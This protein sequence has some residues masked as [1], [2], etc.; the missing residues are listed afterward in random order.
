MMNTN[1]FKIVTRFLTATI[2]L[3][4][5]IILYACDDRNGINTQESKESSMSLQMR[6]GNIET[7][8]NN[9][10]IYMFDANSNFVE[11]K[12]NVHRDL[13]LNQL[14]TNVRVGTWDIVLLTCDQDI[15]GNITVP[16]PTS[17]MASSI[18]WETKSENG[19][20]KQ[21]PSEFRYVML[22]DV[23]IQED[24]TT[25]KSTLMFRNVAKIQVILKNYGGFDP[26]TSSNDEMAY[27]EL[28]EVPT[29]LTW[30]GNLYPDQISPDYSSDP[31]KEFLTFT[32]NVADT[33]NFYVPAHRGDAFEM[34]GG[35]LVEKSNPTDTTE[36]MIKLRMSMPLDGIEFHGL[37]EDGIDIPYA[38]KPNRIIQ[39][40]VNFFG[41]TKLDIKVGVKP[42]DD[43][44]IQE[45]EI[46]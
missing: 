20:L 8:I 21:T 14:T 27:V 36:H 19:N 26:I 41:T 28:L 31:L 6:S 17:P 4:I 45:T 43:W 16:A 35:Q 25:H 11:K 12:L 46:P 42:W 1:I 22:P 37:S 13:S 44:V 24:V 7:F 2:V 40:F 9:T 18:M 34:S 23:D 5:A 32:N 3:L 15:S 39:V 38:P 29:K 30:D 10:N 33:L